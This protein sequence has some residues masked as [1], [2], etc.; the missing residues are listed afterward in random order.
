MQWD[1]VYNQGMNLNPLKG[2]FCRRLIPACLCLLAASLACNFPFIGPAQPE[3]VPTWT[4]WPEGEPSRTVPFLEV[5]PTPA[6]TIPT[7][8]A[9][10]EVAFIGNP[11]TGRIVFTC[12]IDSYDQICLMNADGSDVT[13]L[14][15]TAATDYYASISPDGTEILF[16]SMRTGAFQLYRMDPD[17]VNVERLTNGLG[18]LYA[19]E[20]S[21][22]GS[23][24]VFTVETGG[25]QNIWIMDRDGGNPQALTNTRGG[26]IDPTWSPDG[27]QIA[28]ASTRSGSTQ[29][30][31]M[32]RDGSDPRQVT[33]LP[34]MGGRS[35][36]SPDGSSLA[37]YA[38]PKTDH[39]IFAI[40]IDGTNL[41]QLT[42]GGDNLGPCFSPDGDWITFTSFRDFNNEIYIMRP[43]GSE[44][45]RLTFGPRADW[46]PQVGTVSP[47]P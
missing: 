27:T 26:N 37:F 33:D 16:S 18:S 14:T 17:G 9:T 8:T 24:I 13:R 20:V 1:Y 21:P 10:A 41:R 36:W 11:P 38:G 46:Q 22:D 31:V 43:N 23:S 35:S 28:F 34:N 39:N 7:Q 45:T 25:T 15:T 5:T 6:L 40:N 4:A 19:P 12:S 47:H 30:W 44:Q 2:R 32:E 29:L 42:N 3:L